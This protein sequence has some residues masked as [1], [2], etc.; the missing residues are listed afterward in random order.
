V[1]YLQEDT[2]D[3]EAEK[4]FLQV[5]E[6]T[7]DI[8]FAITKSGEVFSEYRVSEP[9][10]VIFKQVCGWLEL[11]ILSHIASFPAPMFTGVKNVIREHGYRS[12]LCLKKRH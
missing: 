4:I 2:T 6:D 11:L 9:H 10:V 1:L 5:A 8:P 3:D 7:D 12:T